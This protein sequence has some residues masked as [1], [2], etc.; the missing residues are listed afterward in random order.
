MNTHLIIIIFHVLCLTLSCTHTFCFLCVLNW[1]SHVERV[2]N[3]SRSATK[4]RSLLV[5]SGCF[6]FSSIRF[7]GVH[8]TLKPPHASTLYFFKNIVVFRTMMT[9]IINV[10][11]KVNNNGKL[12]KFIHS[13]INLFNGT[14]LI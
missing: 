11:L 13:R 4:T 1:N 6:C 12:I 10:Y 2:I 14:I 3:V 7:E 5:F 9:N 8:F